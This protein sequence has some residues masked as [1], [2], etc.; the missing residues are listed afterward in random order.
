M[1]GECIS[2]SCFIK[3]KRSVAIQ[4]FL[5]LEN[6]DAWHSTNHWSNEKTIIRHIKK[7]IVPFVSSKREALFLFHSSDREF[8]SCAYRHVYFKLQWKTSTFFPVKVMGRSSGLC[9]DI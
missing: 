6:W 5:F 9:E 4:N 7:V 2:I 8:S 1:S 3:A